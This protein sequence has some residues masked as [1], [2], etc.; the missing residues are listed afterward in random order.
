MNLWNEYAQLNRVVAAL[1]VIAIL[2][3]LAFNALWSEWP[4]VLIPIAVSP[5][6]FVGALLIARVPRNVVGWLLAAS[7]LAFAGSFAGNSYAWVALVREGGRAPG[8]ELA[9][10]VAAALFTPALSFAVLMLLFFP[11]GRGL[12][13]RWT[14]VERFFVAFVAVLVVANFL[15][16][17]P[18]E[19]PVT[20]GQSIVFANPFAAH[21]LFGQLMTALGHLGDSWSVPLVLIG[22]LSLFV[23]YRRSDSIERHQIKWLAYAGTVSLALIVASNL[24]GGDLSNWLWV[25]GACLL[26]LLPISIAVAILRYR[27][28]DIDVLIRRTVIYASVSAMLLATYVAVVALLE[29][30]L[31]PVTGGSGVA[32]AISTLAVVALFQPLRRRIQS[33]V[34]HR[35]YRAKYD[36]DRTVD[37]FAARLREQVDLAELRSDLLAAVGETLR[38]ASASV[39]LRGPKQ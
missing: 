15:K 23:R 5:M 35:F 37:A 4:F 6:A 27:L 16:D 29:L 14:W 30:I 25:I 24:T 3:L 1:V 22:P 10:A 21:G 12:G 8:G 18:V 20:N 31:A 17:A 11:S 9:G 7:G 26:G 33:A 32:V 19:V 34:D 28:Y 38:P 36:A 13:G 2:V 39:W